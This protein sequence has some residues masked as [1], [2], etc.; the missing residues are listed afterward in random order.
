M[1]T[2]LGDW[3]VKKIEVE[4]DGSIYVTTTTKTETIRIFEPQFGIG[5]KGK[6]AAALAKFAARNG[7]GNA[8]RLYSF[9]STMRRDFVGELPLSLP[10][11]SSNM[12]SAI[13]DDDKAIAAASLAAIDKADEMNLTK[14]ERAG[15]N[16]KIIAT[17][18]F[19]L[20]S[21]RVIDS[22]ARLLGQPRTCLLKVVESDDADT[23]G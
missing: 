17:A 19:G 18:V 7:L 22:L 13:G 3:N 14:I 1:R 20:D 4:E 21:E 2:L 10:D 5:R 8:R 6:K 15:L 9:L 23:P 11:C 12:A 16:R